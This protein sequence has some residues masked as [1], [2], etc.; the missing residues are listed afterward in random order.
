MSASTLGLGRIVR[1]D[2]RHHRR[3]LAG[4]FV[5]IFV[6]SA[7]VT[8]LG[9][10]VESGIRG[11]LAPQRY[12]A[13][14]VVVGAAQQV[15]VPEDLP[16]PLRER[17]PVP[18]DA[19]REIA[20]LPGVEAVVADVTVPLALRNGTTDAVVEAHPWSATALTGFT[21]AEGREP[22]AGDEAV[23]L[24]GAGHAVGDTLPLA[25][26]GIAAMYTVVGLVSAE[27]VPERAV[28][29]FLT[30]ERIRDLDPHGGA[31]QALGVFVDGDPEPVATAIREAFPQLV[32]R[33]GDAR[34]D[35]EFLDS[36]AARTLL[37]AI[38]SAFVGTCILVALFIVAGTLSLSVQ[39]RRREYALLRAVGATSSQVHS[40]IAREVLTIAVVAALL[41]IAPGYLLSSALQSAF[42]AG[43]VIPGD[44]ALALSPF[45]ALAALVLVLGSAWGAARIAARRPARLDPIEAL[46]ESSTGPGPIGLPRVITGIVF[47]AAGVSI[48]TV[49]LT[50]RGDAA[51]GASAG[52]AILLIVALA[53]LG[54][55]LVA[56]CVRLV[57]P[58]LRRSSAAGFLAAAHTT[59]GSRRM[60]AAV[61]PIALGIGLGLVQIGGPAIV[62]DEAATQA[63]AGVIADL[64]VAAPAGL[65][66]DVV[67]GLRGKP[68][69][70]AATGV[71]VSTAVIDSLDIEGKVERTEYVL[72]GVD[73]ATVDGLL[74]LRV[75]EGSLAALDG[76]ATVAVSADM[77]H[78]LGLDIGDPVTGALGDGSPLE[79]TVVGIYQRGLGFGDLTMAADHIRAHTS[80]GLDSFALVSVDGSGAADALAA[81]GLQVAPGSGQKASTT[82]AVS[83]QGWVSLIG[84]LVILGYIAIAV[85]NTLVMATGERSREFALLQLIGASR[86]QVRATMRTEAILIA[87]LSMVFGVLV[88]IPPLM[89]M[90]YGISGQP[91]PAMP[92]LG[93]LAIIG[94]MG[95]LALVALRVATEAALHRRPIEEIGSRE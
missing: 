45:P 91:L 23:V 13:A 84:L 11:G 68:G 56:L 78:T 17:A 15:D 85:V 47:A 52:A 7:L 90:S 69:V 1:A 29:V 79:A 46:R 25:H 80:A 4:V 26:G 39:A 55:W 53:L 41:G 77:A 51:V 92:V 86:G 24:A 57:G 44:F 3:S 81:D 32:A 18:D 95:A 48:S 88:A 43:G 9:V 54:P 8:G 21:L 20:A 37:V 50:V 28:P 89:G 49:P 70:T 87:G 33:T 35:V 66:P 62:A 61:L 83:Q 19:A 6:A 75:R 64:R 42:V 14:E 10:L 93:S 12:T 82:G 71:V 63:R 36:A 22:A 5:A 59:A 40:L 67:G 76:G 38:G 30:D 60:A 58:V 94:G 72:Q 74:D 65:S 2:L 16:V 34:G 31:A 27:S 73:P